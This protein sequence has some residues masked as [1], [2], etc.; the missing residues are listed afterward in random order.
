MLIGGMVLEN[1]DHQ[2]WVYLEVSR[3]QTPTPDCSIDTVLES[4]RRSA[5]GNYE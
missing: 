3:D 5:T 2:A 1:K 4:T